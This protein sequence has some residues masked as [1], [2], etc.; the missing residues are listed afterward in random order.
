MAKMTVNTIRGSTLWRWLAVLVF[1][2]LL[3]L[4]AH[5]SCTAPANAIEAENCLTGT[6]KDTWDIPTSDIGDPSIQGFAT[7]ISV[8][9]GGTVKFK[10]KTPASAWHLDI[11]RIGYYQGNGARK[12]ATVNPS[13]ALP[14]TQPPCASD[15]ST[16]LT[17]CGTWSVSASWTVPA[18]ATSGIYFAKAIRNDTGGSSHIVFIVRN[19]ASHSDILFQASDTSWQ[20]YNNYTESF[21]G[22]AGANFNSACRAYKLSYNRPFYTRTM[23]PETWVFS[24]EY[25][26]ILWLESNGY[27][28]TYFTDTDSDR[29]GSL[30][31]NHKIWMSNGHDEYWSWSQRA[32][33]E[34]AV[35]AGVNLAFF[36]SNTMYWKTRWESSI[37]GAGVP[38]RTLVCYKETWADASIDPA[39]PPTWTG[40]WRDPRFSPPKD[41]GRPEN[42]LIGTISRIVGPYHSAITVPQSDGLMRF[43]RNT[44]LAT[45]S[46]GHSYTLP[47]GT[48]GAELMADEDNGYRPA[49]LFHLSTTSA[50][51]DQYLL[52][53]GTVVGQG[54]MTHA[55]TLYRHAKQ[56]LSL[57]RRHL[58]L[59]LGIK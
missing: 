29:S 9:Q 26:M 23:E 59:V 43:W 58:L 12:V 1:A 45:L 53:Y 36:S 47:D 2:L 18:N 38:Y 3:P 7:D 41:G 34:A 21:Y 48:L 8:N 27:D 42:G 54:T 31:L 49:G 5:S 39:T 20:A 44:A 33:V 28:V 6:P 57:L 46:S 37:D 35:A 55:L 56:S 16:K 32:N 15:A 11:Y 4:E 40:T 13:V 50:S 51:S 22:C 30:L 10:V 19:D 24:N 17:D 14:Q 25:P 52:N